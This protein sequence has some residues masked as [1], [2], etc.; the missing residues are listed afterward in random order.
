MTILLSHKLLG[1]YDYIYI[2]IYRKRLQN[3]SKKLKSAQEHCRATYHS[4]MREEDPPLDTQ[5][6]EDYDR[7]K[8]IDPTLHKVQIFAMEESLHELLGV[9]QKI[10]EEYISSHQTIGGQEMI[11][12]MNQIRKSMEQMLRIGIDTG[13]DVTSFM[14]YH[15]DHEI[16]KNSQEVAEFDYARNKMTLKVP[17]FKI[18]ESIKKMIIDCASI[19]IYI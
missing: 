17:V 3:L 6:V 5:L 19:Y 15:N 13:F 9:C 14:N 12:F 1:I 7:D 10:Y 18:S 16:M 11:A 2:Y 8:R 4:Q